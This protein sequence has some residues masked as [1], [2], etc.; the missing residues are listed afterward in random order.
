MNN[1]NHAPSN[2]NIVPNIV[3]GVLIFAVGLLIGIFLPHPQS[4]KPQAESTTTKKSSDEE[5]ISSVRDLIETKYYK[6]VDNS[7]LVNGS[8]KGMLD[9]L[10]DPYTTYLDK[11]AAQS[12]NDTISS[13]IVGIG[14]TVMQ[15]NKLIVVDNVVEGGPAK[16]AGI[17]SQDIIVKVNG[18]SV[19]GKE[20][21][22]TTK[23]IR[24]KKG[25][26]VE[27]TV[28][29]D[30]RE[31]DF[32]MVRDTIPVETVKSKMLE[33]QVGLIQVSTFS[34]PTTKEFKKAI[35]DLRDKGAKKFII[36]M[37]G[38]PGG[39]LQQA[40]SMSSMFLK[41]GQVIVKV[42]GRKKSDLVVYRA[43]RKFDQGF[44]VT[45]PTAVLIDHDSASASEI[46][47]AALKDNHIPAVGLTSFGKGTVQ[48][49]VNLP[50]EAELKMTVAKWL[51]PS[52]IWINHK[53]VE[54]DYKV[55]YPQFTKLILNDVK[56]PLKQGDVS[57]DVK[58]FQ[59]G[60]TVLGFAPGNEK[61][62]FDE[63]TENVVK[64]FQANRKITVN[65]TID[66]SSIQEMYRA[67]NELAKDQDL[68][69]KKAV[70]I[71]QK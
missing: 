11:K 48:S 63:Q 51:T 56:K 21:A 27:V 10:D 70:E 68:M 46:F 62:I 61:G 60:L 41:D 26:T 30:D 55:D 8:I 67:L 38:N 59:K 69:K 39:E 42:Q 19:I 53:G 25:T 65:G 29:R 18:K 52:G 47:T 13:S 2:K 43:G 35:T 15:K 4:I 22:D 12:L 14:V 58:S 50:D 24:G 34:E 71:L 54:P 23:L 45:E 5:Y 36:D 16:K 33:Q 31:I 7:K 6:S 3:V 40:L 9:S 66:E 17:K 49:V 64:E 32:K 1:S 44:K 28:K 57:S 37:R 20:T